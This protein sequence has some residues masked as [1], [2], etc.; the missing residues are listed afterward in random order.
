MNPAILPDLSKFQQTIQ[1]VQDHQ[2]NLAL[3]KY[4][5]ACKT[6]EITHGL[7]WNTLI[8]LINATGNVTRQ[9][10]ETM[11]TN[12][13]IAEFQDYNRDVQQITMIIMFALAGLGVVGNL[14]VMCY[15]ARLKKISY[16]F[17][18]VMLAL[19]D[20]L[21]CV[22]ICFAYYFEWQFD[23]KFD[24]FTCYFIIP[25][26][27]QSFPNLSVWIIGLICF[28]R[29]RNMV[30]PLHKKT[31][32]KIYIVILIL[33]TLLT[34]LMTFLT[35]IYFTDWEVTIPA[36]RRRDCP[37]TSVDINKIDRTEYHIIS[38]IFTSLA[39]L[40]VIPMVFYHK[41]ISNYLITER[42]RSQNI[43]PD[44]VHIRKR[45]RKA[46]KVV[47]LLVIVYAITVFP[48][49]GF[50]YYW[51]FEQ[52]FNLKTLVY[53]DY[54]MWVALQYA[55]QCLFLIN[56]IANF[57]IYA[58]LVRGFRQCITCGL[59]KEKRKRKITVST[60]MQSQYLKA[61]GQSLGDDQTLDGNLTLE[62][63]GNQTTDA[64]LGGNQV[65]DEGQSL[66]VGQSH[67]QNGDGRENDKD[68]ENAKEVN[69]GKEE[70]LGTE[71]NKE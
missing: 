22:G 9:Q 19:V 49:V 2:D 64:N 16:H 52:L 25:Y 61:R 3:S 45:N 12:L 36:T 43:G 70:I 56:N 7:D 13:K 27:K 63:D 46:L 17:L 60:L 62:E 39:I 58:Y 18:V 6:L 65:V 1:E 24:R 14:L 66:N 51:M 38:A 53:K 20:T 55:F 5:E 44:M 68:T 10:E 54:K 37:G 8:S 71:M 48:F 33:M 31:S 42:K 69:E 4:L 34:A 26:I 11:R 29:A 59:I 50:N 57:W 30:K 28:E 47:S 32:I 21:F 41:R 15:F 67:I 35:K 23:W 40:P